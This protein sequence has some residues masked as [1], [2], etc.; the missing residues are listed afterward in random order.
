[1]LG[2]NSNLSSTSPVDGGDTSEIITACFQAEEVAREIADSNADT[3]Y[4]LKSNFF[5]SSWPTRIGNRQ[6]QYIEDVESARHKNKPGK[7]QP[8]DGRER[9]KIFELTIKNKN[10][11]FVD[12]Y[13]LNGLSDYQIDLKRKDGVWRIANIRGGIE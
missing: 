4:I 11:A 2:C 6:I 8:F 7:G 12:L 3:V 10:T 9:F 13:W 5:N 1:M